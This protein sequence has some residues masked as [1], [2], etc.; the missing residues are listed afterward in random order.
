M[1]QE[2]HQFSVIATLLSNNSMGKGSSILTANVAYDTTRKSFL[3]TYIP[4]ISGIYSLNVTFQAWRFDPLYHVKGSPFI[5]HVTEAPTNP[6]AS[7]ATGK[8]LTQ[9]KT[10]VP[11]NFTI[12][13]RDVFNNHRLVGGDDIDVVAYHVDGERVDY[14]NVTVS[15]S[16]PL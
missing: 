3:A 9:G 10:G 7:T 5:V 11:L 16:F 13:A 6:G 4:T 12:D 1:Y 2:A 8:G 14:G 15:A